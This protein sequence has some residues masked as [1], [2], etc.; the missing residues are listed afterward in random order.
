MS[1]RL[2]R[3]IT[4][5][6]C[7]HLLAP[8]GVGQRVKPLAPKAGFVRTLDGTKI[9]YIEAGRGGTALLF[10]P[11]WTVPAWI[12]EKQ[13]AHFA[14]THR[15][16]AMDPRGKASLRRHP[17]AYIRRSARDIKAVVDELKL[18]PV[19]LVGYSM[20]AAEVAAYVDQFGTDTLSGPGFCG[21]LGGARL[22]CEDAPPDVAMG[23]RFSARSAQ[24][25]R[26][27]RSLR[28]S[29]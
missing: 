6:A 5:A 11:G 16:V 27:I 1:I 24:V 8:L 25:H 19:V 20:G 28:V 7:L 9:H 15:T 18:A 3:A 23:T 13:I 4:L 10:V 26:R 17:K 22:R 2:T 12:W 21:R 29:V 14:A